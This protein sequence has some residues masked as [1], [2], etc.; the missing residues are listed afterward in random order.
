MSDLTDEGDGSNFDVMVTV[1]DVVNVF[2]GFRA[3]PASNEARVAVGER[4]RVQR[5]APRD[6]HQRVAMLGQTLARDPSATADGRG[7]VHRRGQPGG[8]VEV[9]GVREACDRQAVRGERGCAVGRHTRQ[10]GQDLAVGAGEQD[11]DLVLDRS[12]IDQ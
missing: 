6:S 12:D 3:S 8:G 5:Q 2:P 1:P 7:L 11:S 4:G 9:L 10:A